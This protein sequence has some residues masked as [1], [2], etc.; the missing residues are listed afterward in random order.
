MPRR[1]T[2]RP[3]TKNLRA[4]DANNDGVLTPEEI[5]AFMRGTSKLAAQREDEHEQQEE[6]DD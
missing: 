2:F 1:L 4:M 3:L 5:Q 6:E